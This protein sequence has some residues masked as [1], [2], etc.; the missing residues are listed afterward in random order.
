M[1]LTLPDNSVVY[2][3][4][5]D[6][7]F[8]SSPILSNFKVDDSLLFNKELLKKNFEFPDKNFG[9]CF[10]KVNNTPRYSS[11]KTEYNINFMFLKNLYEL[12]TIYYSG[13][14]FSHSDLEKEILDGKLIS[15]EGYGWGGGSKSWT[16]LEG[17]EVLR[18]VCIFFG[19]RQPKPLKGENVKRNLSEMLI[20]LSAYEVNYDAFKKWNCPWRLE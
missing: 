9:D 7:K 4:I 18:V 13:G 15:H 16:A 1:K 11:K 2:L 3:N 17:Y 19:V 10:R 6:F 12:K 8:Y 14:M 5:A 20:D